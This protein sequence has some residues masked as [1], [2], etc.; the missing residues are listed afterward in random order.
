M[1]RFDGKVALVTGSTQGIGEAVARRLAAEGAAG[2]V[3]CGRNKERGQSVVAALDE[4]GTEA[5]FVPVELGDA[6]SC[7]GLIAAADERFG[8]ID[9]LVNAAGLSLRG[10]IVD[11]S[12]EL[13]DTLMNVNVRA[14]FLLMQGA[15]EIMRREGKGGAIVSVGSVAAYGSVP[16]LTAYA[17]SKGA[18]ITLTKNVAYSVAWDKIRVNV[19]NP[20]WMDTPGEDVIQRRFHSDGRDWLEDAEARQPFGQ[21]IK[22]EEIARAVAF[23]ASDDAGVMTGSSVDYDQSIMGGGA[24]PIPTREETP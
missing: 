11:T 21:L 6:T 22:P 2:I 8:R 12:V 13:W 9:V 3:A 18:L 19:L 20:G 16:F 10:S 1:G 4:L 14:P 7:K 15:I 23:L 17:A 24:Q 5:V